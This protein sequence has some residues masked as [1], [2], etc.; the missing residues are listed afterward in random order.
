MPLYFQIADLADNS[1]VIQPVPAFNVINGNSHAGNTLAMKK[2]MMLPIHG[3]N[4]GEVM[5][6]GVEFYQDLKNVI[7]KKHEKDATSV[8]DEGRFAPRE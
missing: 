2:F 6:I 1:E 4:F 7:N 3:I 5:R 8:G